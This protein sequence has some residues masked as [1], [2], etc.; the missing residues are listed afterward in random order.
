MW[1]FLN[2]SRSQLAN[3]TLLAE[4][5]RHLRKPPSPETARVFKIA[6]ASRALLTARHPAPKI[7]RPTNKSISLRIGGGDD[8]GGAAR[9]IEIAVKIGKMTAVAQPVGLKKL[10]VKFP[11][12][13]DNVGGA[14]SGQPQSLHLSQHPQSQDLAQ[15][16]TQTQS[17]S[18]HPSFQPPPLPDVISGPLK[19]VTKFKLSAPLSTLE[20]DPILSSS[21]TLTSAPK[22]QLIE[23]ERLTRA[24][25]L[26]SSWVPIEEEDELTGGKAGL[27][28][29][30]RFETKKGLDVFSFLYASKVSLIPHLNLSMCYLSMCYSV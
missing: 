10:A 2:Y 23:K 22:E 26:G 7:V 1:S 18:T 15:S 16:S 5:R 17:T 14:T 29:A 25:K 21:G 8:D 28:V 12:R 9:G 27:S 4:L 24:Y 3:E 6:S 13:G 20:I 19:T 30:G 11:A